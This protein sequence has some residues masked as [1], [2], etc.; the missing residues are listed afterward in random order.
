MLATLS[1][2]RPSNK[3]LF[4]IGIVLVILITVFLIMIISRYAA[5]IASPSTVKKV[6]RDRVALLNAAIEPT[7]G[8]KKSIYEM[9]LPEDQALLMNYQPISCRLAGYLDPLQDG[10]FAEADAVRLGLAAGARLFV[11]E[12]SRASD[13]RPALVARDSMG[14]KRSLNDGS[15]Q[16]VCESLVNKT[17]DPIVL[18]LY[19]HDAPDKTKTPELYLSFLSQI[20]RALEPLIPQHLGLTSVGDFTRQKKEN[21][22]FSFAPNFY[23]GKIVVLCNADTSGFRDPGRLGVKRTFSPK[24]DLDFFVHARIYKAE[25]G[26]AELGITEVATGAA[27]VH[28]VSDSYFLL[29]PPDKVTSAV[30]TTRNTFT[31]VMK[32][33][34]TFTPTDK[35][36]DILYKTYGVQ[37]IPLPLN[38]LAKNS[39]TTATWTP[40]DLSLR[41]VKPKPI[42]PTVP[43]TQLNAN[44]G[45]VV[46]PKL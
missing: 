3:I 34:P 18:V 20:A 33:D 46:S 43:N 1:V 22:L 21:E 23:K 15:I 28:I 13:G 44:H 4:Y 17:D 42:I 37:S 35:V 39:G 40:K 31:I 26:G 8:K 30:N 38:I 14:Y 10:A 45:V 41:Y 9:P 29:T 5:K 6:I 25:G 11:L 19:I 36:F 16:K 24:E 12:I 2:P 7:A 27:K 32:K